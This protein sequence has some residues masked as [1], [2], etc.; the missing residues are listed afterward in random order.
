MKKKFVVIISALTLLIN[1]FIIALLVAHKNDK[2][3]L[4]NYRITHDDK[5]GGVYVKISI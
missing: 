4:K 1:A 2:V 3:E 5:F